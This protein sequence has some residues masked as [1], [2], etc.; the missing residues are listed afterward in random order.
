MF[1]RKYFKSNKWLSSEFSKGHGCKSVDR[2]G[3]HYSVRLLNAPIKM[4]VENE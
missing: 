3:R 1:F 4:R 2:C